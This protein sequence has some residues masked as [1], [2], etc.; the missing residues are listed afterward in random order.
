M[1]DETLTMVLANGLPAA[2]NHISG[3]LQRA[4]LLAMILAAAGC[5]RDQYFYGVPTHGDHH[6]VPYPHQSSNPIAVGGDHPRVDQL[7]DAVQAPREFI[8]ACFGRSDVTPGPEP[9]QQA[10]N[11]S[12]RYLAENGLTDVFIDARRYEPAEQWERLKANP[13]M[14]PFWKYTAGTIDVV[15]Y[16]LLPRRALRSDVYSPFTNTL[17][18]NSAKPSGGLYQAARAKVYRHQ[19]WLGTYAVLQRAPLA[20]LIHH[21][22]AAT[23]VLTYAQ[24][25]QQRDLAE[26]LYPRAYAKLAAAVISDALFFIPLQAEVPLTTPVAKVVGGVTGR[27]MGQVV[28][29]NQNGE[30]AEQSKVARSPTEVAARTSAGADVRAGEVVLRRLPSP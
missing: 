20:S 18:I 29:D 3:H 25:T 19:R 1:K 10:V 30:W 8:A 22:D 23:D 16:A 24:T 26:E 9:L 5:A 13:R 2:A 15:G 11:V 21:A 4:V 14:A 12:Q 7:E 6:P 17:S 28:A 27:M